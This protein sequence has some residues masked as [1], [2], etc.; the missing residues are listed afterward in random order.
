MGLD[1]VDAYYKMEG[2]GDTGFITEED[3]DVIW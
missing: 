1:T 3:I 2:K